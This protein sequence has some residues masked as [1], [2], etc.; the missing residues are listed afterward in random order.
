MGLLITPKLLVNYKTAHKPAQ[1]VNAHKLTA[2]CAK[3][4]FMS[5][6]YSLVCHD[7]KHRHDAGQSSGDGPYHSKGN[8]GVFM[9]QHMGHKVEFINDLVGR[10][11]LDDYQGFGVMVI[12]SA[13]DPDEVDKVTKFTNATIGWLQAEHGKEFDFKKIVTIIELTLTNFAKKEIIKIK[14]RVI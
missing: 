11:D 12:D 2:Q 9:Y 5:T 13:I 10:D 7:C 3:R 8:E 6:T 14:R 1:N 4:Q